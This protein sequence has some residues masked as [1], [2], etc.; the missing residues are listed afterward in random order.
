MHNANKKLLSYYGSNLFYIYLLKTSY[1][2][3]GGITRG[4]STKFYHR[5]DALNYIY[6]CKTFQ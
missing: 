6:N 2:V 4:N 3:Y 5:L 1:R